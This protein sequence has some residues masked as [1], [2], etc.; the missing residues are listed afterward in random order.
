[1]EERAGSGGMRLPARGAGQAAEGRVDAWAAIGVGR[2]EPLTARTGPASM[3]GGP[4][5]EARR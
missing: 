4:A 1:M 3:A 2:R 5:K